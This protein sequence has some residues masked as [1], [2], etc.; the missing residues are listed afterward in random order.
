MVQH[1]Y[2]LR[3]AEPEP[4][5]PLGNDFSRSL[6]AQGKRHAELLADWAR[7]SL[8]P[9]DTILCSPAKRARETL[10]PF[11][12]H[13]RKLLANTDYADSMYG[14]SLNML[15]T[16]A[17]DAFG[18]CERLLM[19]GHNPGISLFLASVL[20]PGQLADTRQMSTGTFVVV[21][22][23]SGF[24]REARRGQLRH[25]LEPGDLSGH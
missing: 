8:E 17:E 5:N 20:K 14:A 6:N 21:E 9:P 3:H 16:L 4:W 23:S 12:S 25:L 1:L 11:L 10:A 13:W 18:Y 22:F 7:Q 15:A 24:K 2:L 19:V